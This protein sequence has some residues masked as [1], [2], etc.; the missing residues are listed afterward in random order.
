[1]TPAWPCPDSG[2]G[3]THILDE[4]LGG[5]VPGHTPIDTGRFPVGERAESFCVFIRHS[6]ISVEDILARFGRLE[7]TLS[8]YPKTFAV[9]RSHTKERYPKV[10]KSE[11]LS[12]ERPSLSPAHIWSG[13]QKYRGM[14]HM[15]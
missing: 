5:H 9:S 12:Q 4:T 3:R 2:D 11:S 13:V 14:R 10:K 15:R 7:P 1:M 8:R 6:P